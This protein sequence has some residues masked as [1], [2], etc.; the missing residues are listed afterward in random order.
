MDDAPPPTPEPW[1][2]LISRNAGYGGDINKMMK[3]HPPTEQIHYLYCLRA[4]KGPWQEGER[5]RAFDWFRDITTHE[6]GNSYAPFI[7]TIRDQVYANGTEEEKKMFAAD[8]SAPKTEI[9]KNLPPVKGPG[10]VWAVDEVVELAAHGLEGRDKGKG[11]AM[12]H[13]S[14]CSTCH[15]FGDKGGSQGPDLSNLAGRFTVKD[16][17]ESIIEPNNVI[18]D[19]YGFHEI[20]TNDGKTVVGKILNE[21]DEILIIAINPFDYTQ[22]VEVKRSDIN[23]SKLSKVSPMPAGMINRLN[24]EELKDLLGYL[25]AK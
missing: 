17:A 13:A 6:G 3:N 22:K 25:L 1:A 20:T 18:S 12:F 4:V 9:L 5:R 21:K 10:R 15:R 24:S 8:A 16:L 7:A 14:L 11:E 19:Q 2:D 23:E